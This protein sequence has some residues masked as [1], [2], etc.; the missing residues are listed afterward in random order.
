[1]TAR[2]ALAGNCPLCGSSEIG[3]RR[4]VS[5]L[6]GEEIEVVSCAECA[7]VRRNV[8]MD[9]D[10]YHADENPNTYSDAWAN[11]MAADLSLPGFE[12]TWRDRVDFALREFLEAPREK[13]PRVLEVGCGIGHNLAAFRRYGCDVMGIEPSRAGAR[14]ARERFGLEVVEAYVEDADLGADQFDLVILDS[15]LEHLPDPVSTLKSFRSLVAPGGRVYLDVPNLQA[16]QG[17]L[18]GRQWNIY[19][20]GHINFFTPATLAKTVEAAGL[21]VI[22]TTTYDGLVTWGLTLRTAGAQVLKNAIG[23]GATGRS[24]RS[25]DVGEMSESAPPPS[26]GLNRPSRGIRVENAVSL[27]LGFALTPIRRVQLR[28]GGGMDIWLLAEFSDLS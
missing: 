6:Q 3:E 28:R 22:N 11:A 24:P 20:P 7:L 17:K 15:V 25:A 2:G 19:E 10:R 12:A 14:F 1:M 26:S 8:G 16:W 4:Q 9:R 13:R 5:N 18:L 27:G 21:R 23:K